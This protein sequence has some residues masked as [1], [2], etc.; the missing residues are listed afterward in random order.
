VPASRVNTIEDIFN[1]PFV[2]DRG[3]VHYFEEDGIRVP[4]V[5]YPGRLSQTPARFDRSPPRL[6][7][8]TVSALQEW[9]SIPAEELAALAAADIL[10]V[11]SGDVP[12]DDNVSE[13]RD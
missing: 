7:L 4:S 8:H 3:T 9:L 6:G 11:A 13:D 1:D 2:L 10:R 12:R 5:A